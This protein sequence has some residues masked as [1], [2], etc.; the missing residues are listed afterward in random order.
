MTYESIPEIVNYIKAKKMDKS[1]HTIISYISAINKFL[2]FSK[3]TSILEIEQYDSD[4]VREFQFWLQENGLENS[5]INTAMRPLKALFYWMIKN[6]KAKRNP[7]LGIEQLKTPKI[8]QAYFTEDEER[9]LIS[10]TKSFENKLI[11]AILLRCGLR[12]TE[13]ITLTV[14]N[15]TGDHI[16]VEGKGKRQRSLILEREVSDMLYMYLDWRN[17]KY[18]DKNKEIFLSKYNKP[19]SESAILY[20]LKTSLKYAGF[21][22]KRIKEL[23]VHSLR[24]TFCTNMYEVAKDDYTVQRAMGHESQK[25]TTLYSH[26]RD[27]A[28]DRAMLSQKPIF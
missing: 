19:Y 17:K 21:P 15:F 2:E 10:S 5:S 20:K 28:L 13:L 11:F 14:D 8:E 18:G 23:H 24:H 9:V 16:K 12:R 4:K 27:T 25:T 1:E 3:A 6:K 22:E 26:L 7:F